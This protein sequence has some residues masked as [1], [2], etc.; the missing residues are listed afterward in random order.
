M[1]PAA[2]VRRG[3]RSPGVGERGVGCGAEAGA[4]AVAEPGAG[5]A[6]EEGDAVAFGAVGGGELV[7][8]EGEG[9]VFGG[10]LADEGGDVGSGGLAACELVEGGGELAGPGEDAAGGEFV[11][12]FF[13]VVAGFGAAFGGAGVDVFDFADVVGPV[14]GLAEAA[15]GEASEEGGVIAGEV[16]AGE[17][18]HDDIGGE[19]AE[20]DSCWERLRRVER[21]FSLGAGGDEG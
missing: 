20:F 21:S 16:F 19:G 15:V 10:E 9:G 12:G 11:G 1:C 18:G 17:A 2:G 4:H 7:A 13:V 6:E 14:E 5:D 3:R 8:Y